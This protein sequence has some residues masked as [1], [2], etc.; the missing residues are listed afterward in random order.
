MVLYT[1]VNGYLDKLPIESLAR[2]EKEFLTF[3]HEKNPDVPDAIGEEQDISEK[4]E[5]A[6][7]EDIEVFLGQFDAQK[8]LREKEAREAAAA[9]EA[10]AV[11]TAATETAPAK[12]VAGTAAQ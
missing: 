2:F 3:M 6:L 4:M 7:K 9:A 12:T 11:E 8:E 10:A 5:K 1:G